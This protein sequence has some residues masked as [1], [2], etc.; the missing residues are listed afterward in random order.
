MRTP[1]ELLRELSDYL[2]HEDEG[3]GYIICHYCSARGWAFLEHDT[4][5]PVRE[6]RALLGKC[7]HGYPDGFNHGGGKPC[8]AEKY[9]G[10]SVDIFLGGGKK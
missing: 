8:K 9:D 2:E 3:D 6:V 10:L 4:G 7:P 1:I 5:C